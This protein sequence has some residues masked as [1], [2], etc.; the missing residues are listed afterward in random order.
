MTVWVIVVDRGPN[1]QMF[2]QH[3]PR[4]IDTVVC[5]TPFRSSAHRFDD[6]A[7]AV[8]CVFKV[9]ELCNSKRWKE[10]ITIVPLGLGEDE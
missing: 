1:G 10:C 3:P 6:L 7:D 9:R 5:W 8:D 4:P 2:V